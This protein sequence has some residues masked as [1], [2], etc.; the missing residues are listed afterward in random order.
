[1]TYF[2][3]SVIVPLAAIL[4]G[5]SFVVSSLPALAHGGDDDAVIHVASVLPA[6]PALAVFIG[7]SGS[8]LVRGAKV[9]AVGATT[10]S[11][12]TAWGSASIAWT[13]H[14]NA[15]TV[16]SG[17]SGAGATSDIVAVG[18]IVSFRGALDQTAASAFTVNAT[19]V[20][21]WSKG[22]AS[23][24]PLTVRVSASHSNGSSGS[25]DS[26]VK[27]FGWGQLLHDIRLNIAGQLKI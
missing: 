22:E 12:T 23:Q 24:K 13:L 8:V 9:T 2:S 5:A 7:P 1:M 21:D 27:V 25:S 18:D 10:L 11:A 20:R 17:R 15:R 3:R 14:T 4:A 26:R 6:A 19:A 16:F